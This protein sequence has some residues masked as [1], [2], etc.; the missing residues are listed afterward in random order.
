MPPP[1][2]V[3]IFGNASYSSLAWYC[4]THDSTFRV[5][6]FTVD[7]A[8]IRSPYHENLPVTPFESLETVAPPDT[9]SLLIPIGFQ[10]LNGLRR[11]R[12]LAARKRGYRL[13]SY[14][15]TRASTWPD[16]IL[17]DN[18]MIYEHAIVQ[19]F[20]RIGHNTIVRSG[21]HISYRCSIGEHVYIGAEAAIAG[22]AVICDRSFLGV[23]A[24]VKDGVRVAE[25]S[26]IA[27]GAVVLRD[28]EPGGAYIGNPARR[29]EKDYPDGDDPMAFVLGN[30]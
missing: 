13:I 18:C 10:R 24:V 16:L 5:V 15:S 19:P 22:N 27:P 6:G 14:L 23:G 25:R 12:F 3:I 1:T 4:L 8:C 2:S 28:T 11:D 17:G 20:V 26:I 9:A 30:L 7:A 21:A 29:I